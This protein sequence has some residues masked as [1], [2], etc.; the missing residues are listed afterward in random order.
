VFARACMLMLLPLLVLKP[1]PAVGQLISPGKLSAA[2]ADLEGI[3]SCTRCHR[4]RQSGTAADLCL[5]CHQP[6]ASRMERGE[7]YHGRLADRTCDGCHKEHFGV[8]FGLVRLDSLAFEHEEQAGYTLRGEHETVA[9]RSCHRAELVSDPVV[10][11]AK[12]ARGA[13]DRT[14]LGLGNT[15]RGCHAPDTPHADQFEER[16]CADCHDEAGWS[17]AG[18]FDHNSTSYALT[19]LHRDVACEGCHRPLSSVVVAGGLQYAGIRADRCT[20]CHE[21]EHSGAMPGRCESCHG[22]SGWKQV[23]RRRVESTFDHRAT[24]FVLLG[25]HA[26][27]P[28][29]SC[30]QKPPAGS[31]VRLRFEPAT[32]SDAYPTPL[33]GSCTDCHEDR[34]DGVFLDRPGHGV[35]DGCHGQ[36][37]WLPAD[38]DI[39]RHNRESEFLIDGAHQVVPCASCHPA[40]EG[41][42]RFRLESPSCSDCH[43]PSDPHRGQFRER[44][45][46]S[47]HSGSS[48]RIADFDHDGTRFPLD[49]AHEDV[50]C[51]ACHT[52]EEGPSGEL[53]VRYTPLASQCVDCHGGVE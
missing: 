5:E 11:E 40:S 33:A 10:L 38:Y 39:E 47:C 21:D 29:S 42:P 15:C 45:C 18:G 22:T 32:K 44:S 3:R 14:F 51:E 4:L 12:R 30:H 23:N 41:M 13:L 19:G 48:F 53:F 28:C 20:A 49:G 35:C 8:D 6:L 25:A 9:C 16:P 52:A 31:A 17:G 50:T 1:L 26:A 2:H 36:A 27:A 46:D 37:A 34:H 24:G 43:A 7:G